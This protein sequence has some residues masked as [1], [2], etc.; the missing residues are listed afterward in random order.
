MAIR[1]FTG[2]SCLA[3]AVGSTIARVFYWVS[4]LPTSII[5]PV[6]NYGVKGLTKIFFTGKI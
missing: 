5:L 1:A 6:N 3:L 4:L 2:L